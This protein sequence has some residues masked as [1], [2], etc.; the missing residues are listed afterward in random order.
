M[1]FREL[2]KKKHKRYKFP[3]SFCVHCFQSALAKNVIIEM[4]NHNGS[5]WQISDSISFILYISLFYF[6]FLFLCDFFIPPI[7]IT[8]IQ[9]YPYL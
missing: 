1:E 6:L 3:Y 7:C 4:I 9:A 8:F 2:F 5:V